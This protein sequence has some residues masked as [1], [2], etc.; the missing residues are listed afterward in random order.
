MITVFSKALALLTPRERRR[1]SLVLAMVILMALLETAGVASIMPFLAV[2]GN[3]EVVHTNAVLSSLYEGLGFTSTQ[4]FLMAL[5]GAVFTL[6]LVSAVFR[7]LTH[8]AMNRFIEMRRHSD[9][10][11]LLAP[12]SSLVLML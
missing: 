12:A 2:L 9:S 1:S 11:Q 5:G 10:K 8:Y 4:N 3:P 7:I 6:M